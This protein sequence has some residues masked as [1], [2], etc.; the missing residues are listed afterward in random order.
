MSICVRKSINRFS[1]LLE[2]IQNDQY[3]YR[4]SKMIPIDLE[5]FEI[6]RQGSK[7]VFKC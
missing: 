1:K 7:L 3:L 2:L 6:V 4:I 5:Q